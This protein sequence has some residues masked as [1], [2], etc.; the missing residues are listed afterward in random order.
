[1]GKCVD[2]TLAAHQTRHQKICR[3]MVYPVSKLQP[4]IVGVPYAV[5]GR[6]Q[7]SH[8]RNNCASDDKG[9]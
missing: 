5:N 2:T 3:Q 9:F 7:G 8:G 6:L 1:M 4:R